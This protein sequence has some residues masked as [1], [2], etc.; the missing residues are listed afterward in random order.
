M[1]KV[2]AGVKRHIHFS[3]LLI[4]ATV[5]GCVSSKPK[6]DKLGQEF[7]SHYKHD[8]QESPSEFIVSYPHPHEFGYDSAVGRVYDKGVSMFLNKG[9]ICVN[10]YKDGD[11]LTLLQRLYDSLRHDAP[12]TTPYM[13]SYDYMGDSTLDL[14]NRILHA[15]GSFWIKAPKECLCDTTKIEGI[16]D[17]FEK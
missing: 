6:S 2:I 15:Y 12:F 9:H 5:L 7:M 10:D 3:V 13:Y 14:S 1:N 11:D 4:F 16:P 8:F 17:P